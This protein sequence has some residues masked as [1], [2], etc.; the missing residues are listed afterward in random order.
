LRRSVA[1]DTPSELG[2]RIPFFKSRHDA[3]TAR[4]PS[5]LL[6]VLRREYSTVHVH[7]DEHVRECYVKAPFALR[8]EFVLCNRLQL[9]DR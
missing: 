4:V 1:E 8:M 7:A 5:R 2:R 6:S 9:H 3:G